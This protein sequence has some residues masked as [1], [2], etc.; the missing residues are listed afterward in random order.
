MSNLKE[1]IG[2]LDA[3]NNDHWTAAGLPNV[4]AVSEMMGSAVTRQE[5]AE[6]WPKYDREEANRLAS[7]G[8]DTPPPPPAPTPM[9]DAQSV[10]EAAAVKDDDAILDEALS[11]APDDDP[12]DLLERAVIAAGQPRYRRNYDLHAI[13]RQYGIQQ[14]HIKESQKRLDGREDRR[15]ERREKAETK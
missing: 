11:A 12:I 14:S 13:V 10:A 1:A 5:I 9:D 15:E 6:A 7:G 8:N 4:G 2:K 3:G